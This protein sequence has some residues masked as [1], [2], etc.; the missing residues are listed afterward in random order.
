[1]SRTPHPECGGED[2]DCCHR[3]QDVPTHIRSQEIL[4][5]VLKRTQAGNGLNNSG[6]ARGKVYVKAQDDQIVEIVTNG[7][8]ESTAAISQHQ[9][10]M[11][12]LVISVTQTTFSLNKHMWF[13]KAALGL[14]TILVYGSCDGAEV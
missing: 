13:M 14:S 10:E 1:M 3:E 9:R 2:P 5:E 12:T 4:K 7:T 8:V 11:S 6:S